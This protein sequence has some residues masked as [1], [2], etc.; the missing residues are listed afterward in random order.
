MIN[1]ISDR[2]T[3]NFPHTFF[4]NLSAT[5]GTMIELAQ[6]IQSPW[7]GSVFLSSLSPVA[8]KYTKFEAW[9]MIGLLY[10]TIFERSMSVWKCMKFYANSHASETQ[11]RTKKATTT[12]A[13]DVHRRKIR[14]PYC[15]MTVRQR[16]K[17]RIILENVFSMLIVNEK[18]RKEGKSPFA[19]NERIT[20][21]VISDICAI[22][23]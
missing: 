19:S 18:R 14:P 23:I 7:N 16:K 17:N 22:D 12:T 9:M 6:T 11:R 3:F 20:F 10:V 5:F 2:T 15:A 13:T 21:Q 4:N 8:R 1:R